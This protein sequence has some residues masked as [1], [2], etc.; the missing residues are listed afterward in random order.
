MHQVC[1][2]S[3]HSDLSA[4]A[5]RGPTRTPSNL[6]TGSSN[7][8]LLFL[9]YNDK[10]KHQQPPPQTQ[11]DIRSA[12]PQLEKT[13][14]PLSMPHTHKDQWSVKRMF[15]CYP[16]CRTMLLF[17]TWGRVQSVGL[18]SH[19]GWGEGAQQQ[20]RCRNS[21]PRRHRLMPALPYRATFG[22]PVVFSELSHRTW[23]RVT[24]RNE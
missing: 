8:T 12:P 4:G 14:G 7:G 2:H 16:Y 19:C 5:G 6:K 24:Y 13:V 10:S 9:E 17:R 18:R 15:G 23:A 21:F 1:K 11:Y 20:A 22:E 3:K